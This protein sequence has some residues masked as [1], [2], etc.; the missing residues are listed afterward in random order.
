MSQTTRIDEILR[1]H[2]LWYK[3]PLGE[4]SDDDQRRTPAA[5]SH[6]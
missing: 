1:Q 3:K 2:R 5:R 6:Y 4:D